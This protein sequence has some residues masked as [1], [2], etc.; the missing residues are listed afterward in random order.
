MTVLLFSVLVNTVLSFQN[1]LNSQHPNLTFTSELETN[2]TLPFLDILIDNLGLSKTH[3]NWFIY[4][5]WQF[6]PAFV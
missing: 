2:S 5:F 4:Q 3:F 6:H 1:Y